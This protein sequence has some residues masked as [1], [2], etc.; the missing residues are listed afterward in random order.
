MLSPV[1][2]LANSLAA[3]FRI[4]ED[5]NKRHT[6]SLITALRTN[7]RIQPKS[8]P[9]GFM[10]CASLH[11][12]CKSRRHT[13]SLQSALYS[14]RPLK[15]R[16]SGSYHSESL[17]KREFDLF[18]VELFLMGTTLQGRS[19]FCLPLS[20]PLPQ[21]LKESF[22]VFIGVSAFS[23]SHPQDKRAISRIKSSTHSQIAS[24]PI[25]TDGSLASSHLPHP[26]VVVSPWH[27]KRNKKGQR[28]VGFAGS[29]SVLLNLWS[30]TSLFLFSIHHGLIMFIKHVE[31]NCQEKKSKT[32]CKPMFYYQ[33]QQS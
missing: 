25:L 9:K 31:I 11:R 12:A 30:K 21:V 2:S 4:P 8:S 10:K 6:D 16:P 27:F 33:I 20:V 17:R 18:S 13:G 22:Q 32:K 26:G 28:C 19:S 7:L 15:H 14:Q 1:L 29:K 3:V 23:I 5:A 24:N